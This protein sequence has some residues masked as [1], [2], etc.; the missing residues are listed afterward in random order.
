MPMD[1]RCN[2]RPPHDTWRSPDDCQLRETLLA[3]AI[4]IALSLAVIGVGG[5]LL[6]AEHSQQQA[7]VRLEQERPRALARVL[8][9][10]PLPP[11]GLEAALEGRLHYAT[12]CAAC[13]GHAGQG[14]GG[15]GKSLTN[16]W[17][18]A[19]L[20]DAELHEFIRVGR[21][22]DHPD[23]TMGMPMPPR[24]GNA[25][26]HDADIETIVAYLRG[27]QDF[28]RMP[29]LPPMQSLAAAPTA[30]E[31]EKAMAAAGGDAEL[32]GYIASGAR[33]YA[34]SCS[35]CHGPDAKGV[36]G[37]GPSLVNNPFCMSLDDEAMLAFVKKGRDPGDAANTTGIGMP[38][39]GG[40]PA[41]DDDDIL[42]IIAY[43]R[44]LD[45]RTAAK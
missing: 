29:D 5:G 30:A 16:S 22:A 34:T 32:A 13:H 28:R 40:N 19:S 24:G 17:F 37:N 41:L 39:R 26:L 1:A 8:S 21:R 42:D 43:I 45:A 23:S 10:A 44:S 36:K 9:A 25:A 15:V 4:G 3:T 35:A 2:P 27:M 11:V 33:L 20:T 14:V 38:A 31:V 12:S 6:Y 7:A 18:I